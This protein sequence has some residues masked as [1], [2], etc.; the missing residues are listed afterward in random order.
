MFDLPDFDVMF[1]P[2]LSLFEV[3]LRGTVM[4]F[5]IF[6][7]LRIVRR[8]TGSL[9]VADMLV[10]VL[11]A[12]AAQNG[13]ADDYTSI[14]E[15]VLLVATIIFW[16]A[17]IDWAGFHSQLVGQFL[18]PQPVELVRDGK[19]VRNNLRRNLITVEE[20]MTFVR[21]AGTDDLSQVKRAQLE[22]NG[23]VTVVL[24]R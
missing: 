21:Q 4:Y 3:F 18:H 20:L 14:T 15:G 7:L 1:S 6:A 2:S 16:A 22:G 17:A 9:T 23:E 10:L 5:L 8:E 13:M 19:L 12:D 11:V 24:A